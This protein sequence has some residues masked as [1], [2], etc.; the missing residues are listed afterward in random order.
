MHPT[1]EGTSCT[2]DLTGRVM[3]MSV[4][5]ARTYQAVDPNDVG[6]PNHNTAASDP[7]P[8]EPEKLA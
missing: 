5:V 2:N 7:A 8:V 1:R 3:T 4:G 6:T